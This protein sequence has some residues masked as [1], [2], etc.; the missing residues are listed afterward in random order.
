MPSLDLLTLAREYVAVVAHC[1]AGQKG[2]PIEGNRYALEK[3]EIC[4][5]LDRNRYEM[6]ATKL[7]LWKALHWIDTDEGHGTKTVRVKASQKRQR[8]IVVFLSVHQ[9]LSSLI[10]LQPSQ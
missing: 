2:Q 6:S 9:A 8:M 5:M 4:R 1:V 3:A 10:Q 7:R